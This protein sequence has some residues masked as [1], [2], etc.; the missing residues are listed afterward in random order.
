VSA[1]LTCRA[2]LHQLLDQRRQVTAPVRRRPRAL[3]GEWPAVKGF[4]TQRLD[5]ALY[6]VTP[7]G[8]PRTEWPTGRTGFEVALA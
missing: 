4:V 5:F 8:Q 7:Q 1:C 2:G 3:A 6:A